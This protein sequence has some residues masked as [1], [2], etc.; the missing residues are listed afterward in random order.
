[1]QFQ[2]LR[3]QLMDAVRWEALVKQPHAHTVTASPVNL[4][5]GS[6]GWVSFVRIVSRRFSTLYLKPPVSIL[7]LKQE[8]WERLKKTLPLTCSSP[9]VEIVC[10]SCSGNK[11]KSA[12]GDQVVFYCLTES[13]Y[14]VSEGC[15]KKAQFK[16]QK[17]CVKDANGFDLVAY[18]K[19]K[20]SQYQNAV[21]VT[22][23]ILPGHCTPFIK[24]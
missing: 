1:M 2:S 20:T 23:H 24:G 17:L 13:H 10:H 15:I 7:N 18:D 22:Y 19:E 8:Q 12:T 21:N 16:Q 4:T 6:S 5:T 9:S 14:F 3:G 11:V